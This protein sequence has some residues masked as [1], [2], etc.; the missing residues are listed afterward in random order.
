MGSWG[1][2]AAGAVIRAA[3]TQTAR[4]GGGTTASYGLQELLDVVGEGS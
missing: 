3:E 2:F 1:P 4:F